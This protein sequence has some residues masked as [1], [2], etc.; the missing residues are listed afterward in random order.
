MKKTKNSPL[1]S[2]LIRHEGWMEKPYQDSLGIWTIGVGRN[3][4]RGLAEHEIMYLLE[5]DIQTSIS[6]LSRNL[7]WFDELDD[8]RRDCMIDLHINMGWPRLSKFTKALA[9]ME[10][11]N[12]DLAAYNFMDSRWSKQVKTRA[13]DICNMIR[14]GTYS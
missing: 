5:S 12:W 7:P 3:L 8:V 10:E 11:G 13:V 6:E 2:M 4:S 14:T 1:V 9:A